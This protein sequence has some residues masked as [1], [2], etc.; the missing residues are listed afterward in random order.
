MIY[1]ALYLILNTLKDSFMEC[2]KIS[3]NII[4]Y[5]NTIDKNKN[6]NILGYDYY[7]DNLLIRL[8]Y[9]PLNQ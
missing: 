2:L 5:I 7:V 8:I 3:L 4:I 9:N 6:K 1:T